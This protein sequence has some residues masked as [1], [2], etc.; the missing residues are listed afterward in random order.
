MFS[1]ISDS[2]SEY[3]HYLRSIHVVGA[4]SSRCM[5]NDNK[6]AETSGVV[7]E[8]SMSEFDNWRTQK[9]LRCTLVY[10]LVIESEY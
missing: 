6:C 4:G 8:E 2:S 1:L 10:V 7:R 9:Q 5:D 3:I